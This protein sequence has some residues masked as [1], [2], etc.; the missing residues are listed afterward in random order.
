MSHSRYAW[1]LDTEGTYA[2]MKAEYASAIKLFE[3]CEDADFDPEICAGC[4]KWFRSPLMSK[5]VKNCGFSSSKVYLREGKLCSDSR[6][7]CSMDCNRAISPTSPWDCSCN[8][9]LENDMGC[10]P[11]GEELAALLIIV[12]W[13]CYKIR[14]DEV[15]TF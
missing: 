12:A 1:K 14:K 4:R 5:G 15:Q 9:I 7:C 13:R 11:N 10:T 8:E 6:W 2:K 3:E